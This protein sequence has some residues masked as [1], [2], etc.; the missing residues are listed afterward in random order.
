MKGL[1]CQLSLYPDYLHEEMGLPFSERFHIDPIYRNDKWKEIARW[2]H[3]CFGRW[4]CGAEDPP[5]SYSVTTLDSVHLVSHL[6]GSR[7]T[8]YTN[9]FPD[10]HEYPLAELENL[11][12]FSAHTD[13]VELRVRAFLDETKRLVDSFGPDKVSVPFYAAKVIGLDDVEVSHCPLTIGYRL[14][15]SRLLSDLYDDPVGVEHVFREI[16]T[17]SLEM[18]EALREIIGR[19]K[20]KNACIGACAATFLGPAH[21]REFLLP[22]VVNYASGRPIL[23]HSCG[24]VNGLLDE[25]AQLN[26]LCKVEIFDC[27]EQADID[28]ERSVEAFPDAAISYMFSPPACLTRTSDDLRAAV[29]SV[30]RRT[31]SSPLHLVL[32]LPA[33]ADD[34][35]VDAFFETCLE[36][37]ASQPEQSGFAFV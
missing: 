35:L 29:K 6:F 15:G 13:E 17:M 21:F 1:T 36:S 28:L 27:R 26:S 22:T 30:V 19:K 34:S 11:S 9:A 2:V 10:T 23:W 18:G 4:G 20:P 25:F 32:N 33:G 31:G 12:D 3:A 8:Y 24:R 16:Q 5:D 37:G 14:L 7:I